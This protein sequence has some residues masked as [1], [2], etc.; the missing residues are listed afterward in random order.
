MNEDITKSQK[1]QDVVLNGISTD[2]KDFTGKQTQTLETISNILKES[3][4]RQD[5]T[6]ENILNANTKIESTINLVADVLNTDLAELKTSITSKS[7]KIEEKIKEESYSIMQNVAT[8]F[9]K[10][11]NLTTSVYDAVANTKSEVI[12]TSANISSLINKL[13][14]GIMQKYGKVPTLLYIII[15]FNIIIMVMS[16]IK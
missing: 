9:N 8:E 2:L 12:S 6:L 1:E 14:E 10:S 3:Q 15:L 11:K 13:S 5:A 4:K 7:S 16:L